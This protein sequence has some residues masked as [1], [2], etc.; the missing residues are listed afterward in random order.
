[1]FGDDHIKKI[2]LLTEN[3]AK[4]ALYK[5][6]YAEYCERACVV[7]KSQGQEGADKADEDFAAK[8]A[9]AVTN[10]VFGKVA[11]DD[12]GKKFVAENAN[13]IWHHADWLS[14]DPKLCAILSGAAYNTCYAR[15][16][17]AGGSRGMFSNKFLAYVRAQSGLGSGDYEDKIHWSVK[18]FREIRDNFGPYVIAPLESMITLGIFRPL[19]HNPNE[20]EYYD[21]VHEFAFSAGLPGFMSRLSFHLAEPSPYP[22]PRPP[23]NRSVTC[24]ICG[25][26]ARL[27]CLSCN[28]SFFCDAH[29]CNHLE[30]Y[31]RLGRHK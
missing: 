7:G 12:I 10:K 24:Q 19:S 30:S 16:V 20:R 23:E 15:Y 26:P 1:M 11:G 17:S 2:G 18:L 28:Q 13:L 25:A 31:G 27:Y 4:A 22:L 9:A 5:L 8:L 29:K 3:E 6:L 21:L 14:A